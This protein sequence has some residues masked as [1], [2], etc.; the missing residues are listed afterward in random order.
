MNQ[1]TSPHDSSFALQPEDI[2]RE[3]EW[4]FA[5]VSGE[6]TSAVAPVCFRLL[7]ANAIYDAIAG[8]AEAFRSQRWVS[9]IASEQA[10]AP[11]DEY[12]EPFQ[13]AF[14]KIVD[15]SQR[16]V[17]GIQLMPTFLVLMPAFSDE[18]TARIRQ[19][20]QALQNEAALQQSHPGGEAIAHY[21]RRQSDIIG[22]HLADNYYRHHHEMKAIKSFISAGGTLE[23]FAAANKSALN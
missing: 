7:A 20:Q 12:D 5:V 17:V 6:T 3:E 23:W 21:L 1:Q 10:F 13:A 16:L 14:A 2:A 4:F 8:V 9:Q 19:H 15:A 22:L 11:R 18:E